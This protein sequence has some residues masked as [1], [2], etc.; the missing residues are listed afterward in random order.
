M[1]TL[2]E[3]A[4]LLSDC[5]GPFLEIIADKEPNHGSVACQQDDALQGIHQHTEADFIE[6]A[7]RQERRSKGKG[8]DGFPNLH[9]DYFPLG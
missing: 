3:K 4:K 7:E 1:Q 6:T 5:P 8:C 2:K 9:P